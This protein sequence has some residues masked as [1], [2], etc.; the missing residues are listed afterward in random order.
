MKKTLCFESVY[1]DYTDLLPPY[2]SGKVMRK[3][4]LDL[5]P[6][7]GSHY[8]IYFTFGLNYT[9]DFELVIKDMGIEIREFYKNV[10]KFDFMKDYSSIF[11]KKMVLIDLH[12]QT[13]IRIKDLVS[14]TRSGRNIT[15]IKR[16]PR[17][18]FGTLINLY[19]FLNNAQFFEHRVLVVLDFRGKKKKGVNNHGCSK[20]NCYHYS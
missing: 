5:H 11:L 9:H 4:T 2:I 3:F 1:L 20:K 15:K 8:Q 6:E 18:I 14:L 19:R 17:E 16:D 12:N 10:S 13:C 7:E